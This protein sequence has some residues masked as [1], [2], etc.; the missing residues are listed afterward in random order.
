MIVGIDCLLPSIVNKFLANGVAE[1]GRVVLDT[2]GR[3][4]DRAGTGGGG[5]GA[6][7]GNGVGGGGGTTVAGGRSSMRRETGIVGTSRFDFFAG[8]TVGTPRVVFAGR[9]VGFFGS[10]P[11]SAARLRSFSI[12]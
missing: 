5:V 10:S 9:A 4:S 8:A 11:P 3:S 6:S 7:T 1:A 12:S 2:I